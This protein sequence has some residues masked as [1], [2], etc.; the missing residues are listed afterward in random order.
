MRL[1]ELPG[2]LEAFLDRAR[3]ILSAEIAAAKD[4]VTAANAEKTAAANALTELQAQLKSTQ[5]QL[6]AAVKDLQRASTRVGLDREIVAARKQLD[7]LKAETAEVTTALEALKKQ[8]VDGERRLVELG[9]EANRMIA[10]RVEG[11][12]VMADLRAKIQ[13]VQIGQR[14]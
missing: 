14:P 11:E 6:T 1:D 7:A 9:N 3:G 12:T 13:S 10:I 4:R 8:R 5:D 2:Q